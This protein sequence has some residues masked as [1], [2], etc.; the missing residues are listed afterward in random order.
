VRRHLRQIEVLRRLRWR[1]QQEF[2]ATAIGNSAK[3]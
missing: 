2:I 1:L 3:I